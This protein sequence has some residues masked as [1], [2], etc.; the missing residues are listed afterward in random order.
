MTELIAIKCC[1][2]P[3]HPVDNN[4]HDKTFYGNKRLKYAGKLPGLASKP[5][6]G[7]DDHD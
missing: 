6:M 2:F 4:R 5:A 3:R 1:F 7:S